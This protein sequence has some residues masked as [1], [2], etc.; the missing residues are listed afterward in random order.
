[1][2]KKRFQKETSEPDTYYWP[3]PGHRT[4]SD[5]LSSGDNLIMC[6]CGETLYPDCDMSSMSI[7]ACFNTH[8][9]NVM[10]NAEYKRF[11]EWS[12]QQ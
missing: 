9:L 7:D 10:H 2:F 1:M 6:E 3:V 5:Y 12:K 4:Y 11:V 8:R